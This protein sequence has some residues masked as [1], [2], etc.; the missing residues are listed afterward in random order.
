MEG[1]DSPQTRTDRQRAVA[2]MVQRLVGIY[3]ELPAHLQN[4][5]NHVCLIDASSQ[6]VFVRD[7]VGIECHYRLHI[8]IIHRPTQ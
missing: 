5:L 2:E 4:T 8:Y 1:Q 3:G 6:T 7:G